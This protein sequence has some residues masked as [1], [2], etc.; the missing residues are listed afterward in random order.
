M[1]KAKGWKKNIEVLEKNYPIRIALI[2]YVMVLGGMYL[3]RLI[4]FLFWQI[5][6]SKDTLYYDFI[7][8]ISITIFLIM[9]KKAVK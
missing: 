8:S 2:L 3:G 5:P 7:I 1:D 9:L 4:S 6:I